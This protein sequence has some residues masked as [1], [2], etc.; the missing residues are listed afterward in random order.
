MGAATAEKSRTLIIFPGALGD[1][2]CLIPAIRVIAARHPES[3][4]ELMARFELARLA[5]GRLGISSAHSIDRA[6]VAQLFTESPAEM[7]AARE[8][9][10]DFERIYSFFAADDSRFRHSLSAVA[11]EVCFH[12]FRPPGDGHVAAAYLRSVGAAL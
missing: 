9:F 4:L 11:R 2:I 6:E 12:P 10:V 8:F 3:S 7:T 5:V 1:L